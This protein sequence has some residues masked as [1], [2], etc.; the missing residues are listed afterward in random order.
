[1]SLSE[2]KSFTS[3]SETEDFLSCL[4]IE[5][6]RC[7]SRGVACE[8]DDIGGTRDGRDLLDNTARSFTF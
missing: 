4:N 3:G 7:R 2:P 5:N 8:A 6:R 1:M